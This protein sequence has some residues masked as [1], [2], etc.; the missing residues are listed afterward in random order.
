MALALSPPSSQTKKKQQSGLFCSV[1]DVFMVYNEHLNPT[2]YE[3]DYIRQ[4]LLVLFF[5]PCCLVFSK[6]Q[7]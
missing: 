5:S 7:V 4:D 3:R 6:A 2:G 1:E